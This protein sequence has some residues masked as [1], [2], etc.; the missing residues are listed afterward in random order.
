ML[1]SVI[2]NLAAK[3][4]WDDCQRYEI[5][6]NHQSY[7]ACLHMKRMVVVAAVNNGVGQAV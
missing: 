7:R 6:H 4:Q 5:F 1:H 3:Q 2:A